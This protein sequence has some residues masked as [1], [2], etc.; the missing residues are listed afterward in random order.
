MPPWRG[1]RDQLESI[2]EISIEI[3]ALRQL[4]EIYDRALAFCRRLM[5]HFGLRNRH[6]GWQWPRGRFEVENREEEG[7]TVKVSIPLVALA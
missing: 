2:H 5:A 6:A 3:A 1:V 7:L 4:P